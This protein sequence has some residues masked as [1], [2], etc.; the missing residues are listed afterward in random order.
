VK[1]EWNDKKSITNQKK[2]GVSFHEAAS[3]FGDPLTLHFPIP[4]IQ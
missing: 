4:I 1:F 3:V 2:H